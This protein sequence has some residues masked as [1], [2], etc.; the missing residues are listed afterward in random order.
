VTIRSRSTRVVDLIHEFPYRN[1]GIGVTRYLESLHRE[2]S[3]HETPKRSGSLDPNHRGSL[4]LVQDSRI[5]VRG[6]E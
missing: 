1:S 4:D 6:M 2:L 3:V 5:R